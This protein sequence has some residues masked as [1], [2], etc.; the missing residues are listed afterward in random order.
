MSKCEPTGPESPE[1]QDSGIEIIDLEPS[2]PTDTLDKIKRDLS[3]RVEEKLP[4]RPFLL[5]HGNVQLAAL[6]GIVLVGLIIMLS[7]SGGFSFL[8]SLVTHH[9]ASPSPGSSD[10]LLFHQNTLRYLA[11]T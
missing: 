3:A 11:V 4:A 7:V 8:V 10:V 2:A 6:S 1:E 5:K 9:P